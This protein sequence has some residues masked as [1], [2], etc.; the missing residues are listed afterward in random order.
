MLGSCCPV[1]GQSRKEGTSQ[2]AHDNF[3]KVLYILAYPSFILLPLEDVIV[4]IHFPASTMSVR[5]FS[6]CNLV[7]SLLPPQ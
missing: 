5:V 1:L 7:H 4:C 2:N 6:W 3:L